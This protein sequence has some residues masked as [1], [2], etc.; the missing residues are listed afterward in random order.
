MYCRGLGLMSCRVGVDNL[1]KKWTPS[2]V[3]NRKRFL[4]RPASGLDAI[5]TE[6]WNRSY[7]ELGQ[8]MRLLNE[9]RHR[10]VMNTF[11]CFMSWN[12]KVTLQ[13]NQCIWR[14]LTAA[15]GALDRLHW[16]C[17]KHSPHEL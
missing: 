13:T 5:P 10:C 8:Q 7:F 9:I 6:L 3:E 15:R 12:R 2:P 11:E 4:R 17:S 1:V 14:Q 16:R